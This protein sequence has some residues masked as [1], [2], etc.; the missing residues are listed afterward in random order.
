M[1]E[2]KEVEGGKMVGALVLYL[3]AQIIPNQ[4][5]TGQVS[6]HLGRLWQFRAAGNMLSVLQEKV[7]KLG[8]VPVVWSGCPLSV[9]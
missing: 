1:E 4:S 3:Q 8:G 6:A 2:V 7:I 9:A 5:S